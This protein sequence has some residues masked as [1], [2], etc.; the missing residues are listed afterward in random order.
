MIRALRAMGWLRWRLLLNTLR[1]GRRRDAMERV[2]RV[3]ALMVPFILAALFVG[4]T[5]FMTVA[6]FLG[7]MALAD[8]SVYPPTIVLIARAAISVL[9]VVVIILATGAPG[10]TTLSRYTR[11]LLM[12]IPRQALHLVEVVSNL[13]DPWQV[14]LAAGLVAF[15]A[16]LLAGGAVTA[17]L[18]ALVAGALV[19][20][21]LAS[22]SAAF[23]FLVAWLFRS[24]RRGELF[25][26]IFVMALSGLSLIPAFL[27]DHFESG[28]REGRPE[29]VN[30]PFSVDEF[31]ASLP[32]W[33]RVLPSEAYG[34]AIGH[35]VAGRPMGVAAGLLL[36]VGQ[37]GLLF[38]GSSA[39]HRRV[40]QSLE[41][42]VRRRKNREIDARA[43]RLPFVGAGTSAVAWAQYR[44][45]LRSVRGR[46]IVLFPG[47]LL[48]LMMVI[49]RQL[50]GDEGR[51][52]AGA[53][54]QGY[55]L[56][57]AGVIFGFY[58]MQAFTMNM[59]GA[60][61]SGLTLQLLAPVSDRH[62]AWGKV[63][64]CWLILCAAMVVTFA[65][66]VAVAPSGSPYY[67]LAVFVGAFAMYMSLSPIA[68]WLS[69][70]FPQASDLSKTGSGGNPHPLPM[71][72]GTFL[73]MLA[74]LPNALI[75]I[76]VE[77]WWKQQPILALLG[78][79][80]WALVISAIAIPLVNLS[81]RAVGARREN[82]ALVAQ[83][84]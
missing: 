51:W 53:A 36:L 54:A 13:A 82:L 57:G 32:A 15:S 58:S 68:V 4:S 76:L 61:R 60:D 75:I 20:G 27:S 56:L 12:P 43:L 44:T 34:L 80:I 17:A 39:V 5:L 25:T 33:S 2:S 26:L 6:G 45:A 59:F 40:I 63:Y 48:A 37:V 72:V 49:F 42:D 24:R 29:E 71:F 7:G 64:G 74:A 11:L 1:G 81:A 35:A 67:W 22:L 73:V 47:P 65:A 70:L 46:L 16:G 28:P 18:I 31:D 84:K 52:A 79:T 30:R 19:M 41:G 62:L 23:S 77:L 69:A 78:V 83:G 3:M 10:Q 55:L 21:V 66:S 8:G 14:L 50:P 38:L 9:C